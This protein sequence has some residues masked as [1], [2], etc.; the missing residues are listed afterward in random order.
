[1]TDITDLTNNG[2]IETG[3]LL[4]IFSQNNSATRSVSFEVL[5]QA[6]PTIKSIAYVAPTLTITMTDNTEFSVDIA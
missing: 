1:M 4:V 6:V 3:D 2:E 5:R